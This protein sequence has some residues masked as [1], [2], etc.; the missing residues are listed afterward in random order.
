M[1]S[2]AIHLLLTRDPQLTTLSASDTKPS[3]LSL[4]HEPESPKAEDP[5]DLLSEVNSSSTVCQLPH[6]SSSHGHFIISHHHK[7]ERWVEYNK[8]F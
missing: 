3:T 1:K 5:S 7:E 2:Y 8:T 4:L 6:F